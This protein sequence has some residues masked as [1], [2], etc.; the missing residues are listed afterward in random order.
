[1]ENSDAK[2]ASPLFTIIVPTLNAQFKLEA[3]LASV[4][5]S[6][7]PLE[8]LVMDG[9][10]TDGTPEMLRLFEARM[11]GRLHWWSGPDSGLYD[12]MNRG[13]ERSNGRYLNFL[14]A[15]DELMPGALELVAKRLGQDD[16]SQ[17]TFVLLYGDAFWKEQDRVQGGCYSPLRLTR[18]NICHQVIFYSRPIF[19]QFGGYSLEYP[20]LA[21]Y[22]FNIRCFGD[23]SVKKIH[24]DA[25][26]A[27][28]E[29]GGI[30]SVTRDPKFYDRDMPGLV[31]RNLGVKLYFVHLAGRQ[32]V[33]GGLAKSGPMIRIRR[34]LK[35][36]IGLRT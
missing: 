5:A 32:L 23:D 22:A 8:L 20:V 9:G 10:S 14:G 27:K 33:R 31:R 4:L 24:L 12:A 36:A 19:E 15:G 6:K 7:E 3:T 34:L 1:M 35:R 25:V 17:E 26:I 2:V 11:D 28:F 29:G 16:L 18:E 21:D 30:S 13:I